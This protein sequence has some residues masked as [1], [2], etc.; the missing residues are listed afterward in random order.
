MKFYIAQGIG[1]IAMALVV[2]SFQKN[3][4][5]KL[6]WIQAL[7]SAVF[8]IHFILLGAWTGMGMNLIQIPRNLVF[9]AKTEKHKWL[10]TAVFVGAVII[11]GIFTWE[12]PISLM[13]ICS[14]SL[15]TIVFRMKNPK[16]IR[17]CSLPISVL[18]LIY[19]I[20]SWSIAGVMNESFCL[21]SILIAIIRFR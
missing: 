11:I 15:S 6:L 10:W 13:P 18:W 12:S 7:A 9:A 20:M 3:D 14:I 17:F 19:N 4:K 16:H 21:L 8:A 5:R 2:W 1:F